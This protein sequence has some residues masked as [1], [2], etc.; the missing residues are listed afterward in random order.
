MYEK[1]ISRAN[2][3]L[4]AFCLDDSGSMQDNL[5]GTTDPKFRWV[6]RY[7]AIILMELLARSTEVKAD[8]VVIKP[9]YYVHVLLYGSKP[10]LWGNE[11]MDIEAAVERYTNQGKSLGLGGKLSGTDAATAF[12]EEYRYLQQAVIDPRFQGS[13][14]SMLFHLTDGMSGT[15]ASPIAKQIK[16][17]STQD[18]HV[19]IVNAFIG[20]QTSLKYS[21]PGDFPGYLSPKEAGPS[22]DNLRLFDMSSEVPAC[23]HENLVED[24]IFPSLRPGARLFFDVR[25]K[26]ML[27]HVIQVVGSL[28]SRADRQAR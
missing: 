21:G 10:K 5:P 4:I 16:Q 18:G 11:T 9:R 19:L 7:L 1:K 6:A 22:T 12:Q 2:P 26:E 13:F 25:T 3:G 8:S 14:P 24:G 15:D 17:L 23:I 27:K 28:G 20:T